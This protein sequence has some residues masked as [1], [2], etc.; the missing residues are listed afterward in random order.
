MKAQGSQ[1]AKDKIIHTYIRALCQNLNVLTEFGVNCLI[2]GEGKFIGFGYKKKKYKL[3]LASGAK[4][5]KQGE[6]ACREG[7]RATTTLRSEK[8]ISFKSNTI[9]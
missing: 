5:S 7:S 3:K 8:G 9:L 1:E 2:K 6:A 4:S